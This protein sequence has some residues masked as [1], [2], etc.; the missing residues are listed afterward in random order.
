[1]AKIYDFKS[2]DEKGLEAFFNQMAETFEW[3][4]DMVFVSHDKEGNVVVGMLS[5]DPDRI[6]NTM[7]V[8]ILEQAKMSLILGDED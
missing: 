3:C 8:G 5:K 4:Q 6:C 2:Q 1:M 7:A